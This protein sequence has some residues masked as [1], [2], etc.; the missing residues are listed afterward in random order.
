MSTFGTL[1][2]N[3]TTSL[4]KTARF[5]P[6]P[7]CGAG[8]LQ[9]VYK[10]FLAW[11]AA[12]LAHTCFTAMAA[13][14]QAAQPLPRLVAYYAGWATY[15]GREIAHIDASRLTHLIY[16]FANIGPDGRIMIGDPTIDTLKLFPGFDVNAPFHGNFGQLRLL[17][18]RHPHLKVLIAVGGWSWSGRFSDVALTPESRRRFA[19]SVVEFLVRF[20]F[21]GVDIDWEYPV[22]GGLATNVRRPED[23]QN[24]TL[25]IE[26]LRRQLDAQGEKDGKHY[27]LT[28]AAAAAPYYTQN[29]ELAKLHPL[30]DF[31]NLMTYDLAGPWEPTTGLNAPLSRRPGAPLQPPWSIEDAVRLYLSYGVPPEKLVVG[32]PFYGYR[33]DG[34]APVDQGLFQPYSQGTAVPYFTV[35]TLAASGA[36]TRYWH[37][38]AKVPYLYGG[39]TFITYDDPESLRAK[40]EFVLEHGLG[41]V[42]IWEISQDAADR[43]LLAALHEVLRPAVATP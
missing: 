40:A 37:E 28:F 36:Y 3:V 17:K 6:L 1:I 31:I 8:R 43:S 11:I 19:E 39:G 38:E 5:D 26:E 13:A 21:D 27:L 10:V 35:Q 30:V 18:E 42:M 12:A 24:F 20:G 7:F 29:V 34:V 16:A 2:Y 15:S 9:S 33:F 25:L 4:R 22:S 32:V 14:Q 41:G 23:R